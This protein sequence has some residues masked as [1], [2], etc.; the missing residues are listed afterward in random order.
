MATWQAGM[1]SLP[2]VQQ[3]LRAQMESRDAEFEELR[4][5]KS[6]IESDWNQRKLSCLD[7]NISICF[8]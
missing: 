3:A 7:K 4:A 5:Q 2:D 1:F 8:S 6:S